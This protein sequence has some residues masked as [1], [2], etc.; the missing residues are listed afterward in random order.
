MAPSAVLALQKLSSSAFPLC[1]IVDK[2]GQMLTARPYKEVHQVCQLKSFITFKL[3]WIIM[4]KNY[5]QQET[6]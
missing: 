1:Q 3:Y 5:D 2:K 4:R 6:A